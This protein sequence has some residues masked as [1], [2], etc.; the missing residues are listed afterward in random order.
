MTREV[1]LNLF[2]SDEQVVKIESTSQV[3]FDDLIGLSP[4]ELLHPV[5][6]GESYEL[7]RF[8]PGEDTEVIAAARFNPESN[9][10][11][12]YYLEGAPL[13]LSPSAAVLGLRSSR[14]M[15]IVSPG[16]VALLGYTPW[17]LGESDALHLLTSESPGK[18]HSCTLIDRSGGARD[19]LFMPVSALADGVDIVVIPAPRRDDMDVSMSLQRWG[20]RPVEGPE[21]E[22]DLLLREMDLSQGALLRTTRHGFRIWATRGLDIS[23][24]DLDPGG[25]LEGCLDQ[26]QVWLDMDGGSTAA[27]SSGNMLVQ[28]FGWRSAYVLLLVT[29]GN[30]R[31]VELQAPA[32]CTFLS[33]RLELWNSVES[34]AELQ[35]RKVLLIDAEQLL[36]D[37]GIS[38]FDELGDFL[39]RMAETIGADLLAVVRARDGMQIVSCGGA[40]AHE[41]ADELLSRL[42]GPAGDGVAVESAPIMKDLVLYAA[43]REGKSSFRGIVDS[44][45]RLLARLCSDGRPGPPEEP[46]L[47][48][49]PMVVVSRDF[50]VEWVGGTEK[51]AKC[52]HYNGLDEPCADCPLLGEPT[53]PDSEPSSVLLEREDGIEIVAP[54]QE[55]SI[56]LW[57]RCRLPADSPGRQ[58]GHPEEADRPPTAPARDTAGLRQ[59]GSSSYSQDGRVI[60]WR[61]WMEGATGIPAEQAVG[62]DA[63]RLL[64][65]LSSIHVERQLE[66]AMEKG[67][68]LEEGVDFVL[69]GERYNSAMSISPDTGEI[70]HLVLPAGMS[71]QSASP[72]W[73]QLPGPGVAGASR[74][75]LHLASVIAEACEKAG[76]EFD[77]SPEASS[78]GAP[79]WLTQP[80]AV[81]L[82]AALFDLLG[83]ISPTR[84]MGVDA[85]VVEHSS[86]HGPAAILPGSYHVMEFRVGPALLP[87]QKQLISDLDSEMAAL[88][89]WARRS[90]DRESLVVSVPA[91][92]PWKGRSDSALVY[93]PGDARFA[94]QCCDVLERTCGHVQCAEDPTGLAGGQEKAGILVIRASESAARLI[95]ALC[96]RIPTQPLLLASGVRLR[97]TLSLSPNRR[98]LR[99]PASDEELMMMAR[100]LLRA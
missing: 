39:G 38:I 3:T 10:Y 20:S 72:A 67:V 35:D 49:L 60:E 82:V 29:S 4:P 41:P 74:E 70:S 78:S 27:A 30:I 94:A 93:S 48:R 7:V 1:F 11:L 85:V 83:E 33:M 65:R 46:L 16:M 97:T 73:M 17:E 31:R 51:L 58:P 5:P 86:V 69:R 22:L 54:S 79:V 57:A 63:A 6:S 45:A 53:G 100:R 59:P 84:W 50:S 87:A 36:I 2:V 71:P 96:V 40:I 90:E 77:L 52:Y 76:W 95:S 34:H 44:L 80:A 98:H 66:L 47:S 81:Q 61:S 28:P 24:E 42:S 92:I 99:L 15:P 14:P 9:G 26:G 55:R 23:Q 18:V 19:L 75:P 25:F 37:G 8:T 32:F 64:E 62:Q 12:V 13:T 88:G 68:S 56:V 91:A 89:G 21:E 43:Y